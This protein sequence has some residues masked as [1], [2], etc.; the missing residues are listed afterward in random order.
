MPWVIV[1]GVQDH[2]GKLNVE[3]TPWI[4][5]NPTVNSETDHLNEELR[6]FLTLKRFLR[7]G[8]F[9][10]VVCKYQWQ[11]SVILSY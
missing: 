5:T 9:Q 2:T 11:I 6:Y 7:F 8:P 3:V 10:S 4:P 1:F